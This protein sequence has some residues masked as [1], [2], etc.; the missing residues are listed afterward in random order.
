MLLPFQRP[1]L[2]SR[3]VA[4]L[5]LLLLLLL[6]LHPVIA[7]IVIH[8]ILLLLLLLLAEV[9]VH[10]IFTGSFGIPEFEI[11]LHLL[12]VTKPILKNMYL[13]SSFAFSEEIALLLFS[14]FAIPSWESAVNGQIGHAGQR[15]A[16]GQ[17]PGRSVRILEAISVVAVGVA[18]RII[19]RFFR[20]H[21]PLE[22]D[23]RRRFL[24]RSRRWRRY[25]SGRT[26]SLPS[27]QHQ[28]PRNGHDDHNI[29][30]THPSHI[31]Q[32]DGQ[33]LVSDLKRNNSY[34][35]SNEFNSLGFL[36]IFFISFKSAPPLE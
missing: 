13:P 2:S 19:G 18:G 33:N 27:S 31:H 17:E 1:A 28:P 15:F 12:S 29:V 9:G 22:H 32:I 34:S 5:L 26:P 3:L 25:G 7:V 20:L 10:G 14:P 16:S 21:S 24:L 36:R 23:D 6:I 35:F 11:G 4:L 8:H 30:Q